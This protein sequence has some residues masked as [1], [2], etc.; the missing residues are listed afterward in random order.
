[1]GK[2]DII[3]NQFVY[4]D[5]KNH[6]E[7]LIDFFNLLGNHSNVPFH[8]I[9]SDGKT[10]DVLFDYLC[11][12]I[13]EFDDVNKNVIGG[14]NIQTIIL[15][16]L[17]TT[18][19]LLKKHRNFRIL[20]IGCNKGVLSYYLCKLLKR[21]NVNNRLICISDSMGAGCE[22]TWFEKIIL[23][24]AAEIVTLVTTEYNNDFFPNDYFDVVIING[25]VRF[26]EPTEIISN[27][28]NFTKNA[29][30][31][32]CLSENQYLLN[33][34]FQV[35]VDHCTE[36]VLNGT[37]TVF[38]KTID[39]VDKE[40]FYKLTDEYKI[41]NYKTNIR[42]NLLLIKTTVENLGSIDYL[43][44]ENDAEI[45]TQIKLIMQAENYVL[46]VYS[47]L[48]SINV[49]FEVNELKEAMIKYRICDS[50]KER[51]FLA[52]ICQQKYQVV[53]REMDDESEYSHYSKFT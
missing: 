25:S 24:D 48:N 45:D 37:A 29:G 6:E 7:I 53:M 50:E 1:M 34:C 20:E 11:T 2:I 35:A 15:S 10:F 32:L 36:Y 43:N 26:A 28:A 27:A 14:L 42:K 13:D 9:S 22:N 46:A 47:E 8:G 33:S 44:A 30:L 16:I 17:L 52:E 31:L 51:V 49:K 12:F 41:S 21:F 40:V 18:K 38:S 23:T 4:K 5:D 19:E 39:K 3:S